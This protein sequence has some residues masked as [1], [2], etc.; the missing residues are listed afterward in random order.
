MCIPRR[1]D[2]RS[3][4]SRVQGP[5]GRRVRRLDAGRLAEDRDDGRHALGDAQQRHL[6]HLRVRRHRAL[7]PAE[8]AAQHQAALSF[9]GIIQNRVDQGFG[10][11][12]EFG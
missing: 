10:V 9:P 11:L 2:R 5:D 4:H 8:G 1:R 6:P 3:G 12:L 7:Q